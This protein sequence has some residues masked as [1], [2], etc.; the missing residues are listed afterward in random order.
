MRRQSILIILAAMLALT[1]GCQCGKQGETTTGTSGA[2]VSQQAEQPSTA[3]MAPAGGRS[4]MLVS[5][6]WLASHCNDK[7]LVILH[8]SQS[9]DTYA[10]GHIPGARFVNAADI[11]CM[12]GDAQ[13]QLLPASKLTALVRALGIDNTSRVVVY[14]DDS[15]LS[16]ARMYVALDYLGMGSQTSLLDGHAQKWCAEK[17]EFTT[18]EPQVTASKFIPVL[19]PNVILTFP[20]VRDAAWA[21]YTVPE[22]P[23]ALVDA[24][25]VDEYT[26]RVTGE[27]MKCTGHIPGARSVYWKRNIISDQQPTMCPPDALKQMY[28]SA[29][30]KPG[31]LVI[32]YCRTGGASAFDYFAAKYA[33]YDVRY[34]DGSFGDW[35]NAKGQVATGTE[36]VIR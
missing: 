24:R 8:A 19:N 17:R 3:T 33:G 34:Y 21:A 26:G 30:V 31:D 14:S 35:C 16:A 15:G 32:V 12:Q 22:S 25:P 10:K 28:A 13:G 27:G 2:M 9:R 29:G 6:D 23:V 5:T 20:Q 18:A 11:S 4:D 1:V 7:N 36:N